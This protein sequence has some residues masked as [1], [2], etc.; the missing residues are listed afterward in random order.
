MS[1][2]SVVHLLLLLHSDTY[3]KNVAMCYATQ[4]SEAVCSCYSLLLPVTA[5]IGA[6][7]L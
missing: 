5:F 4:S 6:S 2:T 1:F 7:G 3:S